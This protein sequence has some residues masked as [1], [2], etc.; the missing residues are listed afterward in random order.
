MSGTRKMGKFDASGGTRRME[1]F[2]PKAAVDD[3]PE[4][5]TRPFE[6]RPTRS[7]TPPEASA[8]AFAA[9]ERPGTRAASDAP[10]TPSFEPGERGPPHSDGTPPAS[11]V[12][13]LPTH[14]TRDLADSV[15]AA[16]VDFAIG[17]GAW[18]VELTA[19]NGR[20]TGGQ[21]A[22]QHLRIRP[23]RNGYA[24]LVV[25][26]VNQLEK[27]AELRDFDH[28]TIL[29][30]VRYQ[31]ALELTSPE[32]EQF[33]RKAEV[34]LNGAGIQSMRTPP[35]R[36]LLDQRRSMQRISQRAVVTLVVVLLLAAVVLWRVAATLLAR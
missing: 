3:T 18:G 15:T 13:A 20:T 25:G 11:G 12:E 27:L 5:P 36:E 22:L 4:L 24:V 9:G 28:V 14:L 23:R 34:V 16:F 10:E 17:A 26:T 2:D 35:P 30:E 31:K 21:R 8:A 1:K 6:P 33:L 29:H 7:S 19:A 32:W